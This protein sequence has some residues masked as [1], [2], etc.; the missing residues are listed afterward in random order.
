MYH[1]LLS[2]LFS[3]ICIMS[4]DSECFSEQFISFPH[5]KINPR[6]ISLHVEQFLKDGVDPNKLLFDEPSGDEYSLLCIAVMY[7][8]YDLVKQLLEAGADP[9]KEGTCLYA[10]GYNRVRGKGM[11]PPLFEAIASNNYDMVEILLN[12]GADP[13]VPS[14]H[15]NAVGTFLIQ[16]LYHAV[17]QQAEPSI[18]KLLLNAGADPNWIPDVQEFRKVYPNWDWEKEVDVE[19]P[20][21]APDYLSNSPL[22][23]ALLGKSGDNRRINETVMLLL[24]AGANPNIIC[25]LNFEGEIIFDSPLS[26]A[27][28][29]LSGSIPRSL[30]RSYK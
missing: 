19:I 26:L 8:D 30:L 17:I 9:N 10:I 22:F 11:S 3:F 18:I 5:S 16:P 4:T 13:K 28:K 12:G 15:Y 23:H 20:E 21:G 2:I 14:V 24:K 7:R 29:S 6:K 27:I 1:Q 25:K